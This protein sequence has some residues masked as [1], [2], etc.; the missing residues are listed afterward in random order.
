MTMLPKKSTQAEPPLIE[1]ARR[2]G[3]MLLAM[4]LLIG[5][6]WRLGGAPGWVAGLAVACG[7]MGVLAIVNVALVRGLYRQLDEVRDGSPPDQSM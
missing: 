4:C 3:W 2:L 1:R 5:A 6:L 7:L